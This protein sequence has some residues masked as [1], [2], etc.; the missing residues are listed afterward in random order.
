LRSKW[1]T[2][3]NVP[4]LPPATITN[5]RPNGSKRSDRLRRF[6]PPLRP[7][8]SSRSEAPIARHHPWTSS[9]NSCCSSTRSVGRRPT[10]STRSLTWP[11]VATY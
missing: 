1:I 3:G 6:R 4:P 9:S 10:G 11:V 8:D 7:V 5:R 2:T